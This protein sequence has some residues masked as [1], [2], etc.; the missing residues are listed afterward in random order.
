MLV[1]LNFKGSM[2]NLIRS[3][4][5]QSNMWVDETKVPKKVTFGPVW[6]CF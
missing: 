6:D 3:H 5:L 2:R 4:W 1:R